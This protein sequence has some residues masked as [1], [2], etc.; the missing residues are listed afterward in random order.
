MKALSIQNL[1]KTYKSGTPALK[2]ID[3]EID[4]GDYFALLGPNGAG[5]TTLIG[6]LTSLVTKTSGKVSILG[7][8]IDKHFDKAKACI[9]VVPQEFNFNIFENVFNIV[10]DQAG[11]Y[12]IPA[13]VAQQRAEKYLRQLDLWDKR[14]TWARY[15]SGGMKR[16]LMI[17]RA[18]VHNPRMLILDEP[19]AGVD[20]ELRHSMWKFLRKI[21]DEGVTI[22]LTTH[23]LEEAE[24]QC[25]NIAIIDNGKIIENATMTNVLQKLEYENLIL[26]LK[27]PYLQIETL[28]IP[29]LKL[30]P[31]NATSLEVEVPRDYSLNDL[32]IALEKLG[33]IVTS[34]RTKTSRLESLFMNL[35]KRE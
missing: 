24:T 4:E 22:I 35:T 15:L 26:Y 12:G 11:Y 31:L 21:N 16:R 9:G 14:F 17:A 18:L 1:S 8:D 23:Y 19:T 33:I 29:G 27:E 32:F 28:S 5:K 13:K 34:M 2:G 7:N 3:L 25:R 20:V 30:W 10:V 6:I